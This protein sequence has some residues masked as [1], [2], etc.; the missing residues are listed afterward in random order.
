MTGNELILELLRET[1]WTCTHTHYVLY[2]LANPD[3]FLKL[4]G[5]FPPRLQQQLLPRVAVGLENREIWKSAPIRMKSSSASS[6]VT[7]LLLSSQWEVLRNGVFLFSL[8]GW[9]SVCS[10]RSSFP[11]LEPKIHR[12]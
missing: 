8:G 4:P 6:S 9:S 2:F 10:G 3:A 1:L 7:F 11:S 12:K 5:I